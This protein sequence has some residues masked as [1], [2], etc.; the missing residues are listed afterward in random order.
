MV[1]SNFN[2]I[3]GQLLFFNYHSVFQ[4][5]IRGCYLTQSPLRVTLRR[6]ITT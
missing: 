2:L 6:V 5:T 1:L 4:K 3:F